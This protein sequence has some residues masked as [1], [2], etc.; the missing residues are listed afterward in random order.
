[1][2]VAVATYYDNRV[3]E[4]VKQHEMAIRSAVI[5]QMA[6]ESEHGPLDTSRQ[7]SFAGK[8]P[9]NRANAMS[10]KRGRTMA[11]R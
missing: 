5:M 3:I 2:S 10:R 7:R 4:A 6:Q 8:N 11:K 9:Q 1:M